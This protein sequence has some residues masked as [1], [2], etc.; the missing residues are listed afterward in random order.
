MWGVGLVERAH[1][2]LAQPNV[3]GRDGVGEVMRLGGA[4][5]R[6]CDDGF[7]STQAR[8]TWAIGMPRAA[9]TRCTA[10]AID[11]SAAPKKLRPIGSVSKR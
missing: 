1:L 10:S 6:G 5:N 8:A 4:D 9:A 2:V 11:R 7:F 3:E